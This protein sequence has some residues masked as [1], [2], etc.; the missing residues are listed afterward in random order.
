MPSISRC[1]WDNQL[2]LG[3]GKQYW[4]EIRAV[5][6]A[7]LD[8]FVATHLK[9]SRLRTCTVPCNLYWRCG[10]CW[11]WKPSESRRGS[12]AW[13]RITPGH[14]FKIQIKYFR[15]KLKSYNWLNKPTW[16]ESVRERATVRKREREEVRVLRVNAA[17]QVKKAA[18]PAST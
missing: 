9:L 11:K 10:C 18:Q 7:A 13:S 15:M 17:G 14:A 1:C 3:F 8:K 5:P 12:L 2:V 16:H 4:A 6:I